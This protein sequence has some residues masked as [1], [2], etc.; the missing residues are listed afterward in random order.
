VNVEIGNVT[1]GPGCRNNWH[2]HRGG[3]QSLLVTGGCFK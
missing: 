3:F 1:F 2:S